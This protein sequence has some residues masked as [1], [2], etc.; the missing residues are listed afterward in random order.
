MKVVVCYPHVNAYM[1]ACWREL[2]RR[3]SVEVFVV[4][5]RAGTKGYPVAFSDE[6]MAGVQHR[7]L[8]EHEVDD[9]RLVQSI[10]REQR[11]DWLMISGWSHPIYRQLVDE[12][13]RKI[14]LMDNQ[15]KGTWKQLVGKWALRDYLAKMEYLFVTGERAWQL[16]QYW[17]I[18]QRK[19]RRGCCGIDFERLQHAMAQ[20]LDNQDWPR[21]FVF[22]GRYDEL[23]AI[24]LLVAAYNQYRESVES[25]WPLRCCGMGPMKDVLRGQPGIEDLGF[26]QPA[27]MVNVLAQQ[28]VFVLPSRFDAW[29]LVI[30][31]AC[32]SGLPVICSEACG[33]SVELVRSF[34]NGLTCP[35]Q[36]VDA[37][38]RA[39]RWCHAHHAQLPEMGRRSQELA[40]PYSAPMWADRVMSMLTATP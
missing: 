7:L 31:E 33:S 37:I 6:I 17:E 10:V 27:E 2:S 30:A 9:E 32:A 29:P 36:D 11:P 3:K 22:T 16:T 14:M 13:A 21:S 20:R 18:E 23:K 12:P 4:G 28:G 1:A 39:M 25:P 15:R 24:D 5:F 40:R 19:V 35:T 34:Y 8:A 26:V 38:S